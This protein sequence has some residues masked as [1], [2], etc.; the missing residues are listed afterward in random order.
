[1]NYCLSNVD[2]Q[3]INLVCA[4]DL[5]KGFD[6][7][8]HHVLLK[9]LENHGIVSNELTWFRSYLSNRHQM[10]RL[11]HKTSHLHTLSMGVPQGTCLGI[12]AATNWFSIN[13]L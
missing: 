3:N 9:K 4:L 11:S 10:V 2:K 5:S 13:G 6:T 12:L 8:N 1:M 7:L